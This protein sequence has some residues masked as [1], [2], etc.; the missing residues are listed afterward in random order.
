MKLPEIWA[1]VFPGIPSGFSMKLMI[2]RETISPSRTT[3]KLSERFAACSGSVI[4][5][6]SGLFRPRSAIRSVTS[7]NASCP[8]PVKSKVTA[9]SPVVGSVC[10]S[11]LRI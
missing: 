3:A 5:I 9:I 2:G 7:W 11:G 10:C 8:S 4:P 6:A 1:P